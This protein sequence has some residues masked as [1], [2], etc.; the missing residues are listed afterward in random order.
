MKHYRPQWR[1]IT[2][3]IS[4]SLAAGTVQGGIVRDVLSSIG[5]ASKPPPSPVSANGTP[6]FPRQGFACCNLHNDGDS[7]NDGNYAKYPL[8]P[9]GTPIEVLKYDG[10]RALIKINGRNMKLKHD[11][12]RDQE[13]LDVWVN[14][15][16]V[17][18]DPRPRLAGYPPQVQAA[19]A[20]GK[21]IVGMTREQ[22][23]AA[24]GYPLT[25]ENVSLEEPQWR[26]WRSTHGEYDINFEPNG[27]V[28]SVTGED[29]VLTQ[30]V[31]QGR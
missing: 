7:I 29:E 15:I 8:I 30:M 11:Y 27:R 18:E 21:V 2:L 20:A 5:L 16:V 22:V 23:I 24:I 3:A 25:S 13:S 28:G 26:M 17:N 9:A 19:I 12:G 6:A 31:Y 1:A 10:N 4:L 14:K